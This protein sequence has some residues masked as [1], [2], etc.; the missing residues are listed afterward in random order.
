[1]RFL[2]PSFS[3]LSLALIV[4]GSPLLAQSGASGAEGEQFSSNAAANSMMNTAEDLFAQGK[5]NDARALYEK[6]LELDPRL[7]YAAVYTG[8]VFT[9]QGHFAQA[10]TWY[11]KAVAIDPD[12]ETAYR[13]SATPLMRQGKTREARD[14][15]VE[16][17]VT[18]PYNVFAIAGLKQWGKAT[19]TLLS[20]PDIETPEVLYFDS[21]GIAKIDT[22]PELLNSIEDGSFAWAA[23]GAIRSKWNKEAFTRTF[24]D[25]KE[26]RHSL[27]EEAE[28]LRAVLTVAT[29]D[30][31]VKSLSPSLAKLKKLDREGLLEAYIL[32]GIP[33][34]GIAMDFPEYLHRNR[35]LLREYVIRY[36]LTGGGNESS[37]TVGPAGSR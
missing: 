22:D 20:H 3:I 6:A 35:D 15:Y 24:P 33:D 9:Q 32:I 30:R 17:Y 19:N 37:L 26:Y 10:E 14:R 36:V 29:T 21:V 18:E 2:W 34:D 16:A 11:R 7:Y 4:G 12:R 27:P 31:R 5:L 8:D 13:Y 25:E 1:M 28:A 23:Y